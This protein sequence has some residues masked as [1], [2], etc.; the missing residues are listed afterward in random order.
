MFWAM[1]NSVFFKTRERLRYIDDLTYIRGTYNNHYNNEQFG[2]IGTLN[3]AVNAGGTNWGDV[4][5]ANVSNNGLINN[6]I[7]TTINTVNLFGG[8]VNNA[9][10]IVG[11]NYTNGTYNGQYNNQSGSVGTLTLAGDFASNMGDWGSIGKLEFAE[12]GSGFMTISAFADGATPGFSESINAD[13]VSFAHA[14]LSLNMSGFDVLDDNLV[15]SFFTAFG[16]DNRFSLDL[17]L[18]EMFGGADVNG[19]MEL[20][21]FEVVF[22]A[23]SF[24]IFDNGGLAMDWIFNAVTGYVIY[25]EDGG[26]TV[27]EPAT[28]FML[29]FGLVI[30]LVHR[31]Q[32]K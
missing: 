6:R 4:G 18:G 30:G 8:T 24:W 7:D 21:S 20:N 26:V 28:L 15:A 25:N 32:R 13:Y 5:T 9:G 12:N 3:V 2:T 23:N 17:L 10:T 19:T 1:K 22:G 11:M 27:P 31:R 16:F 29:S 14:N